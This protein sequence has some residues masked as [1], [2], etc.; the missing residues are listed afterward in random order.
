MPHPRRREKKALGE[1]QWA[2][3]RDHGAAFVLC[4]CCYGHAADPAVRGLLP[5]SPFLNS[6]KARGSVGEL[7]NGQV[8]E[9]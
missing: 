5:A 1:G 7:E 9:G 3:G 6:V 4:P 2:P 8:A